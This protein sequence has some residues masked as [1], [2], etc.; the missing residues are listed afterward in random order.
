M[1]LQYSKL[2]TSFSK[3]ARMNF[4][5][6]KEGGRCLIKA[7]NFSDLGVTH[8]NLTVLSSL[9]LE[10]DCIITWTIEDDRLRSFRP[11][12]FLSSP[13]ADTDFLLT[14]DVREELTVLI[15][16]RHI[17]STLLLAF[18]NFHCNVHFSHTAFDALCLCF[19]N[20]AKCTRSQHQLQV[21]S[22]P[23]EFPGIVW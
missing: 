4:L 21:N 16:C 23:R 11:F 18:Y 22:V 15:I 7:A 2:R 12:L 10:V 14:F 9:C 13:T 19:H 17:F 5:V 20:H 8:R 3:L 6:D 1:N